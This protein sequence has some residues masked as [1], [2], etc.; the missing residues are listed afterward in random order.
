MGEEGKRD[1][2]TGKTRGKRGIKKISKRANKRKRKKRKRE[3]GEQKKL[4][5]KETK[6]EQG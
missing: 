6:G 5:N 2:V 1:R 3:T 4:A